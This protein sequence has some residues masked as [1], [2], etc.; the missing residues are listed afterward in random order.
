[1]SPQRFEVF[2]P[3][4]DGEGVD[5]GFPVGQDVAGAGE[6]AQLGVHAPCDL[7]KRVQVVAE[8]VDGDGGLG[9]RHDVGELV[10]DR[11]AHLGEQAGDVFQDI[12][13][14]FLDGFL[15]IA[16]LDRDLDF[17]SV[18]AVCVLVPFRTSGAAD[19]G[20]D[21]LDGGEGAVQPFHHAVAFDE[22]GAG[23]RIGKYGE[24]SFV[25]FREEVASVGGGEPQAQARE[26]EC[27]AQY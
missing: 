10:S 18:D 13:D 26:H 11:R 23:R 6:G 5:H 17:A 27:G 2:A 22:G 25:E 9:A 20:G 4:G 8:D 16:R 14:P 1:M 21:P 3:V 12:V 15:R 19:D 24:G 7:S